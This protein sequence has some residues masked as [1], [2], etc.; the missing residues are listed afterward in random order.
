MDLDR[1]RFDHV[2]IPTSES[3]AGARFLAD[4]GVWLT[5]PRDHP[6]NVEWLRYAPTSRMPAELQEGVHIAYRV[7]DLDEALVG[8]DVLVEPFVVGDGFARLAF[9]RSHG[10]VAELMEY[11]DPAEQGWMWE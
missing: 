9:V 6:L 1:A 7:E 4:D 2:G 10:V 8:A 5:N 3:K 11:A